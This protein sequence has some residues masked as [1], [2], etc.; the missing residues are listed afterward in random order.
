[1]RAGKTGVRLA[2]FE[3]NSGDERP[4]RCI[5]KP[6]PNLP[7]AGVAALKPPGGAAKNRVMTSLANASRRLSLVVLIVGLAAAG[8][9]SSTGSTSSGTSGGAGTL[10]CKAGTEAPYANPAGTP[11]AFPAGVTVEGDIGGDLSGDTKAHCK[12]ADD[13]EYASDLI[14]ACVGLRN[15][16]TADVVVTFPAGLTFVA[17][18][19]ATVNGILIHSHAVTVPAGLSYFAFRPAS[20]NQACNPGGATDTYAFGNVT[21]DAKLL[22]VLGLAKTKKV[23]GDIGAEVVGR[24]I[25]DITDGSGVTDEHRTQL[26]AAPDL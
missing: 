26:A 4:T 23:N 18:T 22:E 15:S 16:T 12:N 24:M 2:H 3:R 25:W 10:Q 13:V 8:C 5:M 21:S 17:K 9:S 6:F 1:M 19:Q 20:L 14:V 7:G 11:M